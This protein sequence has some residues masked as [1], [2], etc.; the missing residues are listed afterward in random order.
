VVEAK[1]R[2]D[3]IIFNNA[4]VSIVNDAMMIIPYADLNLFLLRMKSSTKNEL[5][6]LNRVA[7]EGVIKNLAVALNNV[8]QESYGLYGSRDHGYYNED[9]VVETKRLE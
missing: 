9:R 5:A 2:F 4:P 6:Y 8:T 3:Y 7:Q 1:K